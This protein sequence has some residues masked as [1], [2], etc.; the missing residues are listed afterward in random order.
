LYEVV[1][2]D[3]DIED[4]LEIAHELAGRFDSVADAQFLREVG[5]YCHELPRSLRRQAHDF[6]LLEPSSVCLVTGY[7]V[8]DERIGSTPE[9]WFRPGERSTALPEECFFM[10]CACLLGDP[11][12]WATQQGQKI[13]HDV[14]PIRGHEQLQINSASDATIYWHTEDAFHPHRTEYVGL[15]CLRNPDNVETTYA[16]L[17]GV[18]L[19]AETIS[20]LFQRRY[21]IRPDESHMPDERDW[22]AG[23]GGERRLAYEKI[24]R[25]YEQPQR[26]AV[27]FGD[28]EDPYMRL[29]P[30]FMDRTIEDEEAAAALDELIAALTA[31]LTGVALQ[32]GQILFVDNYKAVHGRQSFKARYDGRDR[33]LKRLNIARDLRKSRAVRAS[34]DSRILY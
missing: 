5:I 1:L 12:G 14:L 34:A 25:M 29:D 30:Y 4:I 20:A 24:R 31:N 8:N 13:M 11:I 15:M 9:H 2:T 3:D 19:S 26:V 6:R 22:E 32:P 21:V 16:S 27:L 18:K 17:D 7:P 10:L 23:G 33:W 28:P